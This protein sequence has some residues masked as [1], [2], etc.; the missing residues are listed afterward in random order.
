MRGGGHLGPPPR[1]D[2]HADTDME[3]AHLRDVGLPAATAQRLRALHLEMVDAVLA[4]DGL[5]RV[6]QLASA[7]TEGVVA[8]VLPRLAAAV[9]WPQ[10]AAEGG[11]LRD[12]ERYVAA[13]LRGRPARVPKTV[14]HELAI[15]AGDERLGA[16]LLLEG[17]AEPSLEAFEVLHLAAVTCLTEVAIEEAREEVEQS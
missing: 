13:R 12:L 7:G 6:A 16:V 14:I 15:G 9:I 1:P 2:P 10:A 5:R 4:G 11:R 17:D 8:I 3:A